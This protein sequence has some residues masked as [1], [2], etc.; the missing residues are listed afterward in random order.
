[1]KDILLLDVTPLS[2]GVETLGGVMTVLIP[3]NTTIPTRKSETFSTAA[4]NQPGVEIHVMQGERKFASDNRSL[5]KF[6]LDG[7]PPAPCAVSSVSRI[8]HHRAR[9][10]ATTHQASA[11]ST[12]SFA[13][14]RSGRCVSSSRRSATRRVSDD[15]RPRSGLR[16]TDQF[17]SL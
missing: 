14:H 2:L 15:K 9:R 5:G 12:H 6:K 3:R 10:S 8:C 7:I 16:Q 13:A 4:D 1:M 17:C 11:R